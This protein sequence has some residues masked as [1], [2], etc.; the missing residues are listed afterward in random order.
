MSDP[1]KERRTRWL[2]E[3][4]VLE[5][6]GKIWIAEEYVYT[7]LDRELAFERRRNAGRLCPHCKDS[8]PFRDRETNAFMHEI[9]IEE[10][11]RVRTM[12]RVRCYADVIWRNEDQ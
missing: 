1:H 11:P 12:K 6:D 10:N 8:K 2:D 4:E 5:F 7:L 9:Y 3:A